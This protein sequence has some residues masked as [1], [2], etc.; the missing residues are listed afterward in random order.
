[1]FL[2]IVHND[3]EWSDGLGGLSVEWYYVPEHAWTTS[4]Y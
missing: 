2:K 3:S 4:E 1:V